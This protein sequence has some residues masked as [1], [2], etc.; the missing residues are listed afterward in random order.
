MISD[1]KGEVLGKYHSD[2][3]PL[4]LCLF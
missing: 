1:S 2:F 4:G 3:N